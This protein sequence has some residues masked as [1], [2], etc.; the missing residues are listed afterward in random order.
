MKFTVIFA[1]MAFVQFSA[2][3]T[4]VL[5]IQFGWDRDVATRLFFGGLVLISSLCMIYL[6]EFG[7][8]K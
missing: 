3:V 7:D 8:T 4:L 1:L 2:L 5:S 6:A